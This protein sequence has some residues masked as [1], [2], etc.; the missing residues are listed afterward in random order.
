MRH[1]HRLK[2]FVFA[3]PHQ[4]RSREFL[5]AFTAVVQESQ[6]LPQLEEVDL[7]LIT[8]PSTFRFPKHCPKLRKI[9]LRYAK[10]PLELGFPWTQS[11]E[12][13]LVDVD[14]V[15]HSLLFDMARNLKHLSV[16]R[17]SWQYSGKPV[18]LPHLETL[19]STSTEIPLHCITAP[20]LRN[21]S[22]DGRIANLRTMIHC[23]PCI[24]QSL[25]LHYMP[26]A[27][28]FF[29][30]LKDIPWLKRLRLSFRR[31][32]GDCEFVE[33]MTHID[34]SGRFKYCPY[35]TSL[36]LE[37]YDRVDNNAVISMVEQRR[38]GY[39][40]IHG[41]L[42]EVMLWMW[43]SNIEVSQEQAEMQQRVKR[44]VENGLSIQIQDP[45]IWR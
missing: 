12:L 19:D 5:N 43:D 33:R 42:E 15:N 8:A 23:S 10:V 13:R 34:E 39:K 36:H 14:I 35:L 11:E 21:I 2:K 6:S 32:L 28:D 16:S 25:H 30:L 38:K 29:T 26:P 18:L 17:C 40:E 37:L 4:A 44:L 31:S 22:Y 24:V 27:E 41:G 7:D 20:N 9:T 1:S 3:N 45:R